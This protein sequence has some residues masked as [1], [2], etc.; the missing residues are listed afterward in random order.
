MAFVCKFVLTQVA[1][2]SVVSTFFDGL[3]LGFGPLDLTSSCQALVTQDAH[4]LDLRAL[5]AARAVFQDFEIAWTG[6]TVFV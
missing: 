1:Q 2:L 4:G 3:L 6:F 5:T